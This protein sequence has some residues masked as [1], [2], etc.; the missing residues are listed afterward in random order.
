MKR[1]LGRPQIL[2][3][4]TLTLDRY[5]W[6]RVE[7]ISPEAPVSVVHLELRALKPQKESRVE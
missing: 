1:E 3:A 2:V 5:F 7:R 4:D 6:E